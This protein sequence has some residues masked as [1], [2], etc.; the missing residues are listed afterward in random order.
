VSNNPFYLTKVE[1]AKL[2]FEQVLLLLYNTSATIYQAI[3]RSWTGNS[4]N[5]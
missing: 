5:L 2:Q 1:L 4:L 3:P